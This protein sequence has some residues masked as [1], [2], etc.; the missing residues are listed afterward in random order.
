MDVVG[1]L[2]AESH[3]L[4][5]ERR[6]HFHG[7]TSHDVLD[8]GLGEG[9]AVEVLNLVELLDNFQIGLWLARF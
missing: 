9:N 4:I 8:E 2:V 7:K 3:E 5:V 6:P 1:V